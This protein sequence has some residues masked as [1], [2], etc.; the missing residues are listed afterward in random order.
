MNRDTEQSTY[1]FEVFYDGACPLC[2]REIRF[3]RFADR[4]RRIRFTDISRDEFR[5]SD[6]GTTQDSLMAEIHGRT[7]E[8]TWVRGV[9]VFRRLYAAIGLGPVVWITRLPLISGLLNRAY[10]VFARNRL[11]WTGRCVD[12]GGSCAITPGPKSAP[13]QV[14]MSGSPHAGN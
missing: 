5:A 11:R 3:L 13:E 1:R 4:R 14:T 6:Y 2:D 8:G 7:A 9:E 10:R 12:R